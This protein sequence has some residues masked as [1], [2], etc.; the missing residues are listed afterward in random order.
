MSQ[1]PVS[2]PG[3]FGRMPMLHAG[4][5]GRRELLRVGG[6]ALGGLSLPTLL[7]PAAR[8]ELPA[9]LPTGAQA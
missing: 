7:A 1:F 2:C 5:M 4:A 3:P 9:A 8:A 6:V